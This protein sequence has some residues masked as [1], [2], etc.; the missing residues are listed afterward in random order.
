VEG[1][2]IGY[3]GLGLMVASGL[4]GRDAGL[5]RDKDAAT[6]STAVSTELEQSTRFEGG[7]LGQKAQKPGHTHSP[8]RARTARGEQC[9]TRRNLRAM[10]VSSENPQS[11]A[12]STSFLSV[13]SSS[14]SAFATRRRMT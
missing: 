9:S 7:C 11:P 5:V 14:S 10:C 8:R 2:C 12:I 13:V 1:R 3:H 4:E 6:L